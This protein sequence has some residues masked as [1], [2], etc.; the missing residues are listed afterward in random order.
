MNKLHETTLFMEILV[1]QLSNISFT[2]FMRSPYLGIVFLANS[3]YQILRS[4]SMYQTGAENKLR[5]SMTN[6]VFMRIL[7]EG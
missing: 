5:L 3:F 7:S 2:I 4:F 6:F 1:L